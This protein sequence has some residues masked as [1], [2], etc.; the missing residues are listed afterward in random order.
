MKGTFKFINFIDN[1]SIK[2]Y[3]IHTSK[4]KGETKMKKIISSLLAICMII[5]SFTIVS[6]ENVWTKASDWAI[7]DLNEANTLGLFPARLKNTDLTQKITRAEQAALSVKIYEVATGKSASPAANPFA[8]TNDEEVL[9]ALNLG[10]TSGTSATT[11]EP[12]ANLTR[13]QAATMLS[14]IYK[15]I[16]IEGWT[17][18]KDS[19]FS[20]EFEM[21]DKFKDHSKISS[22]AEQSVYFMAS[23]QWILGNEVKEFMPL[24]N[25]SREQALI[26]AKRMATFLKENQKEEFKVIC[27]GGSLTASDTRW[28]KA[29]QEYLQGK[30]P[31]KKVVAMNAGINKTSSDYGATRFKNN[32][33]SQ[34]P[35]LVIIDFTV[36]D[37]NDYINQTPYVESMLRQCMEAESAPGVILIHSPYPTAENDASFELWKNSFESKEALAKHYGIQTINVYQCLKDIYA[38]SGSDDSFIDW[39]EHYFNYPDTNYLPFKPKPR[40]YGLIGDAIVAAFDEKGIE[41]FLKP[42]ENKP[43]YLDSPIVNAKYEMIYMSDKKLNYSHGWDMTSVNNRF[44]NHS[45]YDIPAIYYSYPFFP[46]GGVALAKLS[47]SVT[48]KTT[49]QAIYISYLTSVTYGVPGV[50]YVDEKQVGEMTCYDKNYKDENHISKRIELP[51]DGEKTVTL[52]NRTNGAFRICAIIEEYVD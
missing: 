44:A 26:I 1:K 35:D 34:N 31:Q 4:T 36:D 15:K 32:V 39:V 3:N 9:K 45:A 7:T 41:T 13:E 28:I 48:F 25:C 20:F 8:D 49:A 38:E 40:A 30:M 16:N 14:R 27:I 19:E 22:W 18:E 46:E 52:S 2:W 50:V 51:S 5:S 21:P 42:I 11:F 10:V 6:A 24:D 43:A 17:L 12:D 29:T 37:M 23:K 47:G 33:L